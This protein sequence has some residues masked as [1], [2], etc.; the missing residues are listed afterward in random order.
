MHTVY[1]LLGGNVGDVAWAFEQAIVRMVE[2]GLQVHKVGPLFESEP[3][4]MESDRLFLNQ[5]L[6]AGTSLEPK[7]LLRLLLSIETS[8]GRKRVHGSISSRQL[9][10][11]IL[12]YDDCVLSLPNLIIPHPRLHARRFALLP[13]CDMVPDFIHPILKK[14]M[15]QL[16]NE[17]DDQGAVAMIDSKPAP[18]SSPDI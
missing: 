8:L 3:W 6:Q 10:L 17:C 12:F 4:G 13:L 7:E 16:L 5:L 15:Q 18:R 9:D 1:L 11:D 14:T 2:E